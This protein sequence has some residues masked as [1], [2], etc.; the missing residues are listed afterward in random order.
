M[1]NTSDC[2]PRSSR[3]PIASMNCGDRPC[4]SCSRRVSIRRISGRLLA[5]ARPGSVRRR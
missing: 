1:R 5:R 4:L 3:W 2:S